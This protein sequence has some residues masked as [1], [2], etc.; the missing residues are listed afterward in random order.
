MNIGM[1][2]RMHAT[3]SSI[4][5]SRILEIT[6]SSRVVY[7]ETSKMKILGVL[8]LTHYYAEYDSI[9]R[10]FKGWWHGKRLDITSQSER[11]A[12]H[13]VPLLERRQVELERELA[14]QQSERQQSVRCSRNSLHF[15]PDFLPGEF[16]FTR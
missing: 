13:T 9:L 3:E 1:C 4:R 5:I 11:Q 10:Y 14:R 8:A 12:V 6:V 15:S 7:A 16:C 2:L